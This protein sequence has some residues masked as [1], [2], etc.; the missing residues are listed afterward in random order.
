MADS[1]SMTVI[2]FA[3]WKFVIFDILD[4]VSEVF[5]LVHNFLRSF[6]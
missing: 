6:I 5:E 4:A 3:S 2:T 1:L